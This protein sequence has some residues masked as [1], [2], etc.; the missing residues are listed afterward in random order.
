M[1]RI[2]P[3]QIAAWRACRLKW[4]YSYGAKL[5][6]PEKSHFAA[7]GIA[8]HESVEQVLGGRIKLEEAPDYA[9]FVLQRELANSEN[10]A[11]QAQRYQPG[12]ARAIE[13]MPKD[14]FE[15]DDWVLEEMTEWEV[16]CVKHFHKKVEEECDDCITF[17]GYPDFYRFND[18]GDI[19]LMELKSTSN[20]QL[21][22]LQFFLWN[23]QHRYYAVM[24]HKKYDKPVDVTYIVTYTSR[25]RAGEG[26]RVGKWHMTDKVLS[27]GETDLIRG[28][29]EI[30]SLDIYPHYSRAC[31][32]CD[33]S[34]A[35][36][37]EVTGGDAASM[38][39][40]EYVAKKDVRD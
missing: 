37:T 14:I 30:G 22:P 20:N 25:D 26:S 32:F 12:T 5:A 35:C 28:G 1:K 29:R 8:I 3:S 13:R 19:D 11:K 4:W 16:P 23:P 9:Y 27:M 2:S 6:Y 40:A 18:D 24:L 38:I 33:F 7:S 21:G 39:A 34:K 31:D 10:P 15:Y 17:F 36:S